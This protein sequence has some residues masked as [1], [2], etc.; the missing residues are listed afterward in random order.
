MAPRRKSKKKKPSLPPPPTLR[1]ELLM[2]ARGAARTVQ[3]AFLTLVVLGLIAGVAF[4]AWS[5]RPIPAF[6]AEDLTVGSPFDVTFRAENSNPWFAMAKLRITCVVAE[7]RASAMPPAAVEATDVRFPA[8]T[9]SGLAPGEAA[10]FRCPFRSLIGHPINDD[11][12]VAQRAEIYFRS[13]YDLELF[14]SFRL[15]DNSAH[16]GLDM[17]FLPPRWV[18][19]P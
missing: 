12:A 11:P 2:M 19:K 1:Q 9:P 8:G 4:A 10:T 16:F 14:R 7:V 17:R 6:S 3:H 15:S 13:E 5:L 18:R